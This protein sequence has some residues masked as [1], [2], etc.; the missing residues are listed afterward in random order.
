MSQPPA[1]RSTTVYLYE[2]AWILPSIAIPVGMLAALTV[3]AFGA[4]I[5]LP[6]VEGR[7]RAAEVAQQP[8]FD[9]PGVRQTAP[10]QYEVVM[11]S[12]IWAFAPNEIRVPAG[13]TVTFVTT[14]KDVVHG[15]LI[16]R[17]HVNVMLLPG[18]I[19]RVTA[20]FEQPGE[21]PMFCHEYCG[22][23]HHTMWGKVIVE[24]RS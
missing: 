9:A 13:S 20:R 8:P 17:A 18:Q 19:S 2:L 4:G 5:H 22:I 12:Q 16:P 23:A 7:V 11:T 15:L 3:T 1:K 24:P 14:S 10:G 21:F 6:S